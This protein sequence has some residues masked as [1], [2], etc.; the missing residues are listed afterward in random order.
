MKV[1]VLVK[2]DVLEED[3]YVCGVFSSRE[4]AVKAIY[5]E[6]DFYIKD[7][8]VIDKESLIL[9]KDYITYFSYEIEEHELD[10]EK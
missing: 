1:F 2:Y 3:N 10:G 9:S 6:V 5:K 8:Y 7:G 4:N